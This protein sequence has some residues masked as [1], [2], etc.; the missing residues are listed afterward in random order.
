MWTVSSESH[1]EGLFPEA[2]LVIDYYTVRVLWEN[3]MLG[4]WGGLKKGAIYKQAGLGESD[5]DGLAL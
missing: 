3:G 2:T 1:F 5:K 4:N